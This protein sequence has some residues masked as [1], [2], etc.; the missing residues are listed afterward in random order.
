MPHSLIGKWRGG[1]HNTL[2]TI[3]HNPGGGIGGKFR[4][5]SGEWGSFKGLNMDGGRRLKGTYV[6]PDA[7]HRLVCD[8]PMLCVTRLTPH[9]ALMLL[10]WCCDAPAQQ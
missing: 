8:T 7:K 9:M 2:V 10:S 6:D 1:P 4:C 5:P 3:S